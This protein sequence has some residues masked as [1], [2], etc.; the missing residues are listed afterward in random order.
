MEYQG[1]FWID[2]GIS[3]GLGPHYEKQIEVITAE[4]DL[5]AIISASRKAR[6]FSRNYLSN[7]K[8]SLTTVTLLEL[9][10]SNKTQI[11]QKKVLNQAGHK[12]LPFFEWNDKRELVT[13]CST[14]EH[15]LS[16]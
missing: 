8:N 7:P 5:T 2:C 12:C 10:D 15:L 16:Y 13:K 9:N 3:P 11:N 14:L 6:H 4:D 1:V